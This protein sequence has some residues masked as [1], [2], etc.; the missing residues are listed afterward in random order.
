MVVLLVELG[1]SILFGMYI[2]HRFKGISLR[3]TCTI[4]NALDA[5][6]NGFTANRYG[7]FFT[8]LR[9]TPIVKAHVTVSFAILQFDANF[10]WHYLAPP[11]IASAECPNH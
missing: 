8:Y 1:R 4:V 9:C 11:A 3:F 10:M 6:T 2:V 5:T 7:D